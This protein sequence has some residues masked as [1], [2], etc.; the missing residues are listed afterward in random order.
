MRKAIIFF[1]S[2]T[3]LYSFLRIIEK[4]ME[5]GDGELV[6]LGI[7]C[8]IS[9]LLLFLIKIIGKDEIKTL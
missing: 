5:L 6:L 7:S 9:V 8:A 2:I 1:L 3:V 4:S